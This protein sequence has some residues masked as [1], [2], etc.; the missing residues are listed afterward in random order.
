MTLWILLETYAIRE[1]WK[2]LQQRRSQKVPSCANGDPNIRSESNEKI[3]RSRVFK[4]N[5]GSGPFIE[6]CELENLRGSYTARGDY[7]RRSHTSLPDGA[8]TQ[9]R[10]HGNR[11]AREIES[12]P[13]RI[14]GIVKDEDIPYHTAITMPPDRRSKSCVGFNALNQKMMCGLPNV[15]DRGYRPPGYTKSDIREWKNEIR[16]IVPNRPTLFL[17]AHTPLRPL[18]TLMPPE[19][20]R[21]HDTSVMF[22]RTVDRTYGRHIEYTVDP[23]WF[24]EKITPGSVKKRAHCVYTWNV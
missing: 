20:E 11:S 21:P 8:W 14:R 6:Q 23:E 12:A 2:T 5:L 3:Q 1:L 9:H 4:T 22:R 24:S 16:K 10:N 7:L 15:Y 19:L 18:T 17:P 13:S